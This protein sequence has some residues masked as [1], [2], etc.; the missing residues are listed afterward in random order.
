VTR[1]VVLPSRSRV[2]ARAKK[3]RT[4]TKSGAL[5]RW[6]L[7]QAR[8]SLR[9]Q[10]LPRIIGC[11]RT[12]SE[13]QIWWRPHPTSNSVGNLVLHLAGNVRQWIVC[14]LGGEQDRR[15]REKE[16]SEPGPLSR[17]FLIGHVESAVAAAD[18]VLR[19]LS[20]ADLARA[21]RIQGFRVT[22]LSA[23]AH[24]TEHFA[25]HAGQIIYATK[26]RRGVDLG[27]THLPGEKAKSARASR[28]SQY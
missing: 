16:F 11:L 8:H 27:F 7:A 10:H 18:R 24:V 13:A 28:L 25:H 6:F 1:R 9:E 4:K 22:G 15:E 17:R 2:P 21:Y 5:S 26:L 20:P 14:G 19:S 12:L 3:G 23:I